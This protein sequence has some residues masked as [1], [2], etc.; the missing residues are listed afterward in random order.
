VLDT[1]VVIYLSRLPDA[2]LP[3]SATVATVTLAELAAGVHATKDP[4]ERSKRITRLLSAEA[5]FDPLP[6][7]ANAAH[8]YGNLV[9]LMLEIGRD[10]K[11]R[12][13]DLMIAATALVNGLPLY[14]ANTDGFRGLESLLT[15]VPVPV[16]AA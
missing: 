7:D 13:N 16:P 12:R 15:I 9:A 1:C 8:A 10:P 14:T 11:P 6:F 4:V 2:V 5:N 3:I